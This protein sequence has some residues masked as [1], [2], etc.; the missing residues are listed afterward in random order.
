[1]ND[2][3]TLIILTPGFPKN[4]QDTNCMP[5]PQSCIKNLK[6]LNPDLQIIVCAFQYPYFDTPYEW[7]GV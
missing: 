7:H 5:F 6:Q 2:Q 3:R 4:E 1:M